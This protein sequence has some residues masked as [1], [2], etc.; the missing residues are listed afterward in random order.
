MLMHASMASTKIRG[1]KFHHHRAL[2]S[3]VQR[4]KGDAAE[5]VFQPTQGNVGDP[6]HLVIMCDAAMATATKD[7]ELSGYFIY[8]VPW[9][10]CASH[11]LECKETATSCSQ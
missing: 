6:F 9:R 1:L 5:I 2:A 3:V 8:L 10:R 4:L 7:K 11:T